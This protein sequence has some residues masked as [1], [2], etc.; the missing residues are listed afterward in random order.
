MCSPRQCRQAGSSVPGS[1]YKWKTSRVAPMADIRAIQRHLEARSSRPIGFCL[2]PKQAF[3]SIQDNVRS[4]F[5]FRFSGI[6]SREGT[7]ESQT[8]LCGWNDSEPSTTFWAGLEGGSNRLTVRL[9]PE[10]G[11][12][13]EVW[14]GPTLAPGQPFQFELLLHGGMGPGGVLF[15][16]GEPDKWSSL[17]SGSTRGLERLVWPP[18]WC[19]GN[20]ESGSTDRPFL[21]QN[22]RLECQEVS[23]D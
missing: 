5:A 20:G 9:L 12:S 10:S 16:R 13:A 19:L 22:L 18:S 7:M 3:L 21:G 14:I 17:Q 6:A 4:L 2:R 1:G 8:L 11:G 15:R 23:L